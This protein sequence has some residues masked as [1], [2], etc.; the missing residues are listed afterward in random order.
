MKTEHKYRIGD[1]VMH[2]SDLCPFLVTGI[3]PNEVRIYGD[4]SGGT[5]SMR[6]EEWL[7]VGDVKPYFDERKAW[8]RREAITCIELT[9]GYL[10]EQRD[11]AI[12][13]IDQLAAF[14]LELTAR[15]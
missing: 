1:K 5:H 7:P 4:F 8:M 10:P 14:V 6:Q 13:T 15:P 11:N 2:E 9:K 3:R 12:Q